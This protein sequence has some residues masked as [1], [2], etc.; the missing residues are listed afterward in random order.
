MRREVLSAY[1]RIFDLVP[2]TCEVTKVRL[3]GREKNEAREVVYEFL[4][5]IQAP[6]GL[7]DVKP[8]P[9]EEKEL[10]NWAQR[11][12]QFGGP[13]VSNMV[14][15]EAND[16]QDERFVYSAHLVPK[17]V[18]GFEVREGKFTIEANC[19]GVFYG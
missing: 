13:E 10:T 18:R 16:G 14:R 8:S 11:H 5:E 15:V 7:P 4:C 19:Y 12:K 17:N 2:E 9:T 3:L 6:T 1:L